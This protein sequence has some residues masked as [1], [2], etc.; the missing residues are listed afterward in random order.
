MLKV[1]E[2]RKPLRFEITPKHCD[3]AKRV[4]PCNCVIAQALMNKFGARLLEVQVLPTITCLMWSGGV[5]HRYQTPR[6]LRTALENWDKTG[7]WDLPPGVYELLPVH[8]SQTRRAQTERA[9][10]RRLKGDVNMAKRYP[11]SGKGRRRPLSPRV[12]NLKLIQELASS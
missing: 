5:T 1:S 4:G 9:K 8:K 6:I 3:G 10:N 7:Q 11:F 2:P 12:I